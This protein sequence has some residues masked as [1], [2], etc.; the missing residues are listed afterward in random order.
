MADVPRP[1]APPRCVECGT[2]A[3]YRPHALDCSIGQANAAHWLNVRTV[4]K[5]LADAIAERRQDRPF[6][7]RLR[8]RLEHDNAIL[9]RLAGAEPMTRVQPRDYQEWRR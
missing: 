5:A 9:D 2:I 1:P 8:H 7:E 3:G 6:M 4:E